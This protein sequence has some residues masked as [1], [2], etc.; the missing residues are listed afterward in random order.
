MPPDA[1]PPDAV[2]PDAV[3]PDAVPPDAVPPDAVPPDAVPPDAVPPDAVPVNPGAPRLDEVTVYRNDAHDAFGVLVS[4]IDNEEDLA[5][6]EVSWLDAAGTATAEAPVPVAFDEPIVYADGRF[7]VRVGVGGPVAA[8]SPQA[9]TARLVAIDLEGHVGDPIETPIAPVPQVAA[10]EECDTDRGWAECAPDSMCAA[11]PD[12]LF[13]PGECARAIRSCPADWDIIELHGQPNWRYDGDTGEAE[14]HGRGRCGGGAGDQLLQY[15]AANS[16][17]NYFWTESPDGAADTV[18]W[19]RSH[20]GS[21]DLAASL[22]CNDDRRGADGGE[23]GSYLFADLEASETA[24]LFV[25]GAI[26]ATGRRGVDLSKCQPPSRSPRRFP[27]H[28]GCDAED[29]SLDRGPAGEALRRGVD[30]E[31]DLLHEIFDLIVVDVGE[32]RQETRD[33]TA[34]SVEECRERLWNSRAAGG[35]EGG[36]R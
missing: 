26:G 2:L 34:K 21:P 24:W 33:V 14:F 13:G 6:F 3:P 35:D 4:G 15:T 1:V 20:C 30:G 23:R 16:G 18:M 17:R 31:E 28:V 29:P 12:A 19:A 9:R 36:I 10:G 25:G 22:G 7:S 11:E 8:V 32:P 5:H 27:R